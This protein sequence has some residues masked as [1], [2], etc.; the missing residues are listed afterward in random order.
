MEGTNVFY[1]FSTSFFDKK[2]SE[3]RQMV[4]TFD[5]QRN[6]RDVMRK[7]NMVYED[8]FGFD[9]YG[10]DA[11][12]FF[13][14]NN[15]LF[16]A[17]PIEDQKYILDGGKRLYGIKSPEIIDKNIESGCYNLFSNSIHSRYGGIINNSLNL[18][19]LNSRTGAAFLFHMAFE[20]SG[21]YYA[22]VIK[23]YLKKRHKL[24]I[25]LDK[26]EQESV[27]IFSNDTTLMQHIE[28]Y[29]NKYCNLRSIKASRQQND[30]V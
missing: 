11:E 24:R 5:N 14:K 18:S 21:M 25:Y 4:Y 27:N 20:I 15:D 9:Q 30:T 2:L 28:Y 10:H 13:L 23:E 26:D 19:Y 3:F 22:N 8:L 7:L 6:D 17:L 1:H 16:S 29:R 12:I